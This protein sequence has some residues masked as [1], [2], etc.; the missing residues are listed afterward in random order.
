MKQKD[1]DIKVVEDMGNSEQVL[2]LS[3]GDYKEEIKQPNV[4]SEEFDFDTVGD[5]PDTQLIENLMDDLFVFINSSAIRLAGNYYIGRAALEHSGEVVSNMRAGK[6]LKSESDIPVVNTL[7]VLAGKAV[8]RAFK[9]DN[10]IPDSIN[11]TVDFITALPVTEYKRDGAKEKL[12]EK[13]MNGVHEVVVYV[14]KKKVKVEIGFEFVFVSPE[15]TAAV[16]SIVDKKNKERTKK[17]L[18]EFVKEYEGMTEDKALEELENGRILH[19]DIGEGTTELPITQKYN[20]DDKKAD[21]INI[22]IAVAIN[23]ALTRFREEQGFP[24]LSR[25]KYSEYLKYP[26][27]YPEF[28]SVAMNYIRQ[29]VKGPYR[30][31]LD[32]I[33][34]QLDSVYN[35]VDIVM[36]YGG[37]SILMKEIMY[38]ALKEELAGRRMGKIKVLWVPTELATTMNADGLERLFYNNFYNKIKSAKLESAKK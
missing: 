19:V 35:E 36:V 6:D 22:G 3:I 5:K 20:F 38:D 33:K 8:Q 2:R 24:T 27:Q 9:E 31:V 17:L 37:G 23:K 1:Y 4:F 11:L 30:Q 29:T 34:D 10:E 14:G 16:F 26:K 13:F 15:G 28:H 7:G 12:Q 18:S 25:Q 21:G 32:A